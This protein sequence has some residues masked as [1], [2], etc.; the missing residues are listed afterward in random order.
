MASAALA[1]FNDFIDTGAWPSAAKE[2]LK[3]LGARL[4]L[5]VY[6][7]LPDILEEVVDRVLDDPEPN[8]VLEEEQ[9]EL[10]RWYTEM[11][12]HQGMLH[13]ELNDRLEGRF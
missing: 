10:K 2:L 3:E 13:A 5:G 6:L 11:K 4:C 9:R 12:P 7:E 8:P 1:A